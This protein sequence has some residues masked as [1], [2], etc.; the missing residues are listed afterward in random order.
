MK[1]DCPR[2]ALRIAT[3]LLFVTALLITLPRPRTSAQAQSNA[4]ST[5]SMKDTRRETTTTTTQKTRA[6]RT[7]LPSERRGIAVK[8]L[9]T[10]NRL[11]PLNL[12]KHRK[13]KPNEI[14][15]VRDVDLSSAAST[16]RLVLNADGSRIRL[17]S[18]ESPGAVEMRVHLSDFDL[19]DGDEVY[20]Y[21]LTETSPV[22]GPY[23]Q[24]GLESN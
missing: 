2:N 17:L 3:V 13:S 22:F 1:E 23:R 16:S 14:G 11:A 8:S 9:L 7:D 21:G 5:P 18:I 10:P 15:V 20:I 6:S 19:P 12:A 24:R 4:V